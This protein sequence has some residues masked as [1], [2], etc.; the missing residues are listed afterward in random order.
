MFK[1]V[2]DILVFLSFVNFYW[3]FIKS[4][5]KIIILLISIINITELLNI[6]I[7][8][9]LDISNVKNIRSN[10]NKKLSRNPGKLSEF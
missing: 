9:K 6:L 5:S 2:C 7:I 4:F 8:K 3:Q 10:N 1:L